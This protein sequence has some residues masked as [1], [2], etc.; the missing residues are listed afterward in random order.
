MSLSDKFYSDYFKIRTNL[1]YQIIPAKEVY[2]EIF[3]LRKNVGS[4]IRNKILPRVRGSCRR[5][6]I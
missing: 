2:D 6:M 4:E 3:K 1:K 5:K